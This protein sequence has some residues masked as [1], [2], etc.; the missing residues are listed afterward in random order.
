MIKDRFKDH[1][2]SGSPRHVENRVEK[3]LKEGVDFGFNG[4]DIKTFDIHF[5][6]INMSEA[7]YND[8]LVGLTKVID[9]LFDHLLGDEKKEFLYWPNRHEKIA[10]WKDKIEAFLNDKD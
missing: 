2:F 7:E 8:K 3:H 9:T 10:Q 4:L 6:K 5:T 1:F